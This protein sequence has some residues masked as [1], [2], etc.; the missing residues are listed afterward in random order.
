[1]EISDTITIPS[2]SESTS[3][4]TSAS[5]APTTIEVDI[6]MRQTNYTREEA[7][8]SLERNKTLEASISEYLEVQKK[9][10][11]VYTTNQGIFKT[12]RDFF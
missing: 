10:K 1:M 4:S 3:I 6:L 2:A 12:I 11:P 5:T 7:V 9:E 8:E